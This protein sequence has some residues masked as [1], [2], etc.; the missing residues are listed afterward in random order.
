MLSEKELENIKKELRPFSMLLKGTADKIL[1]EVSNYPIFVL[2]QELMEIGVPLAVPDSV[3]GKWSINISTLEEL[4]AK[5]IIQPENLEPF[6]SIFKDPEKFYCLLVGK[7][8]G[9]AFVFVP[10][11]LK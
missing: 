5:K 11:D 1:E 7:P 8:E 3:E 9:A 4:F 10:R 2:Q 6:K